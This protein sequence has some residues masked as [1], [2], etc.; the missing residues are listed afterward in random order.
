MK[1]KFIMKLAAGLIF[2]IVLSGCQKQSET[3]AL[4]SNLSAHIKEQTDIAVSKNRIKKLV[5]YIFF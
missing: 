5:L 3:G 1:N 2:V 4:K